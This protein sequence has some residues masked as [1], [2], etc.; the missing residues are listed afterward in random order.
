[1]NFLNIFNTIFPEA[2]PFFFFCILGPDICV[3]F[4]TENSAC[5]PVLNQ[6]SETVLG[7]VEKNSSITLSGKRGMQLAS[8][9]K[10]KAFQLRGFD[11]GFY[12]NDS[13]LG[14][15]TRLRCEQGLQPLI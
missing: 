8:A 15:L 12:N 1:M 7:E 3:Q 2:T 10:N 5:T 6:I 4:V 11:E 14:S 9:S 13:K